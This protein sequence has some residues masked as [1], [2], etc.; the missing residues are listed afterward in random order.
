[1]MIKKILRL[2]AWVGMLR[3]QSTLGRA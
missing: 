1:V 2:P 3:Y